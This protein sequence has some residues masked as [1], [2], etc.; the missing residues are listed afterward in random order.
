MGAVI[1]RM[2]ERYYGCEIMDVRGN[3][4]FVIT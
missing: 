1:L 2:A 3:G 4:G